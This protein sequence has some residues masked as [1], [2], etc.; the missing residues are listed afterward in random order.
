M[1]WACDGAGQSPSATAIR[2]SVRPIVLTRWGMR[3]P[4]SMGQFPLESG[5][6][7]T[8]LGGRRAERL[9]RS[10]D[11]GDREAPTGRKGRVARPARAKA[12]ASQQVTARWRRARRA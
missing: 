5:R 7:I 10:R 1:V 6:E 4:A 12:R 8:E 9:P 2:A 3:A 11:T